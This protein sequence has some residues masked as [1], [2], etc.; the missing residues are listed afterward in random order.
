MTAW[1][2]GSLAV[3]Y[4][5]KWLK[6]TDSQLT[7][8]EQAAVPEHWSCHW[9]R[10]AIQQYNAIKKNQKYNNSSNNVYYNCTA[11]DTTTDISTTYSSVIFCACFI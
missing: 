10:Y 11:T 1:E 9:D 2:D 5:I 8:L 7:S 4:L 6:T 3:H